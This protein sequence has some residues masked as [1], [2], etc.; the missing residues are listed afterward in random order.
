MVVI[1]PANMPI[2]PMTMSRISLMSL[3]RNGPKLLGKLTQ[4]SMNAG[5][6]IPNADR[7]NA[8]NREM[9]RPKAGIDIARATVDKETIFNC[10][11]SRFSALGENYMLTF[12]LRLHV[13]FSK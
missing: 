3:S 13:A 1:A 6:I 5:N 4:I 8:P 2:K 9:N 11:I 12:C 7:H 10:S